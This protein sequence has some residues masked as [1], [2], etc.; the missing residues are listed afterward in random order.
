MADG[1][2]KCRL[3]LTDRNGNGYQEEKTFVVDSRAPSVKINLEKSS[4]RAG[5]NVN[6]KV[7]ADSD[8]NR[9]N[10]KFYG[11]KP[12]Q[13]FWSKQEKSN[14]GQLADS[15]KSGFGKIHFDRHGGRFRAQSIDR[16][17]TNRGFG[18][19]KKRR[20]ENLNKPDKIG[21]T[22][23]FSDS[24]KSA[25]ICGFIFFC[26]AGFVVWLSCGEPQKITAQE[27][28]SEIENAL[29][30]RQE[31]F[32]AEAIVPLPTAE[33]RENLAKLVESSPD[34][35]QMLEKLAELDEKLSRFDEAEKNL[36]H[37]AEIDFAKLENLAAFYH[38][39]ARFEKEADVLNRILFSMAA[40]KRAVVFEK[41]IDLARIHDLKEYLKSGILRPSDKEN[42]EIFTDF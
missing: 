26:F 8:T 39:R 30:T 17:N 3:L 38:R 23:S 31:F 18:K 14:V 33:A 1:T 19:M 27:S 7:S 21:R 42:P 41:L 12:V 9:L 32:G 37:L 2:Y 24:R 16:R 5:E 10:A 13:L 25:I 36:I 15:R 40:E 11:A 35:P 29:F 28:Q 34:N 20:G 6:L 4:F 22:K